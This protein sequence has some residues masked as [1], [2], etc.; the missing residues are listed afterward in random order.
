MNNR[1]PELL[2]E[3]EPLITPENYQRYKTRLEWLGFLIGAE[4]LDEYYS[5]HPVEV[6]NG[7]RT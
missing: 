5:K 1:I 4:S 6:A 7:N 2:D 3:L